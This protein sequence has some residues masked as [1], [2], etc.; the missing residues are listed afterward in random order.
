LKFIYKSSPEQSLTVSGL[1]IVKQ[2]VGH[3]NGTLQDWPAMQR[4]RGAIIRL[5]AMAWR[6]RLVCAREAACRPAVECY[7]RRRR[8]TTS[9][10]YTMCRRASNKVENPLA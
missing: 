10:S 5:Q 6:H 3:P 2:G 4:Y 7:R 9:V 8:Q 1:K